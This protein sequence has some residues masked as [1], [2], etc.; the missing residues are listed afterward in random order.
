[1]GSEM[2]IRDRKPVNQNK[3][4]DQE[5]PVIDV[6]KSP[7]GSLL[8]VW[9]LPALDQP[10]EAT[11]NRL[12]REYTCANHSATHLLQAALIKVLG[13]HVA[14]KGSLVNQDYLRFD[15]THFEAMTKQQLLDVHALVNEKIRPRITIEED[16]EIPIEQA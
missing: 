4:A 12:S 6:Q 3:E 5:Y 14:Q 16:R 9:Q 8:V 7:Y 11:V 13:P 10:V 2:C 1:M 15:F